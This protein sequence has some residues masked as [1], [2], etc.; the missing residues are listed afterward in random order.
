MSPQGRCIIS[1]SKHLVHQNLTVTNVA[2][3]SL[4]LRTAIAIQSGWTTPNTTFLMRRARMFLQATELATADD[5]PVLV[6]LA[7][8]NATVG[9]IASALTQI[10][11]EGPDDITQGLNQDQSWTVYQDSVRQFHRES[12]GTADK[13]VYIESGWMKMGGKSGI[14]LVKDGG[15][16]VFAYNSGNGVLTTGAVVSGVVQIQGTWLRS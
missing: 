15:V 13:M 5:G 8:G 3:G 11:S 1:M 12:S 6:G 4:G 7:H 2:L 16:Q 14:P 10:N 9:E